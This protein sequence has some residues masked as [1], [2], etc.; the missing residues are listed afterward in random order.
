MAMAIQKRVYTPKDGG[1]KTT[2]W[3]VVVSFTDP[4]TKK[5]T[6]KLVGT[7]AKEAEAKRAERKALLSKDDGVFVD[8]SKITVG[9]LLDTWLKSKRGTI[10]VNSEADYASAIRLHLKP[11]LGHLR[12]QKLN[13]DTIQNVYDA[14]QDREKPLQPRLIARCHSVL[15]QAL[16]QAVKRH[17]IATN[18][19]L[20]VDPPSVKRTV[21]SVWTPEQTGHFL[22]VAEGR[23]KRLMMVQG[24]EVEAEPRRDG[25]TPLWHFLALEGMRRSEA[26]GLRWKDINWT[27]GTAHIVQQAKPRKRVIVDAAVA[28]APVAGLRSTEISPGTK[29]A[30]GTRSVRLTP[31]TLDALKEHR[32]RQLEARLAAP[33]WEDNDLILCTA[34]GTPINGNNVSRSFQRLVKAAGLPRIRVHDLRHG[35]ATTLLLGGQSAKVVSERLGHANISITLNLYSHVTPHMQEEAALKMDSLVPRAPKVASN[36]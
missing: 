22:D 30:S 17:T 23:A 24:E 31:Q 33:E 3:Q 10:S 1:P 19:A 34:R 4:A 27:N 14:W 26:L 7:Y 29:T 35:A 32:T 9:E 2:S 28:A 21:Q 6:R 16:D 18:V 5:R 15:R 20:A 11:A 13:A 25:L 12:V 36:A 8:P